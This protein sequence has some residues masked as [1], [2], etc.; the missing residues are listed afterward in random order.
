MEIFVFV[1]AGADG[2]W[3]HIKNWRVKTTLYFFDFKS[4][5]KKFHSSAHSIF[6]SYIDRHCFWHAFLI[7][8]KFEQTKNKTRETK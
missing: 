5:Q 3:K 4:K 7:D 6:R 1:V 2:D 8:E